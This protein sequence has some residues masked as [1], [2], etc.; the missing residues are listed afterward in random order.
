MVASAG[1]VVTILYLN[2]ST[3]LRFYAVLAAI[4]IIG[5]LP[6]FLEDYAGLAPVPKLQPTLAAW[7]G[8]V[9]ALVLLPRERGP[10]VA[11]ADHD[12]AKR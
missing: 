6:W 4:I 7:F 3:Y 8:T 9:L 2:S 11:A 10:S 1:A 5:R 12:E